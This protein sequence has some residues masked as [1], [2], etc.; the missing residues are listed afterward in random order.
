M[1][2]PYNTYKNAGLPPGPIASPGLASIQAALEPKASD[3]Y[4]YVT[5]KDGSQGHLFGK[6]YEEHLANIKKSEQNSP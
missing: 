1:D 6:T 3:Y 2:S 4:F 5:K